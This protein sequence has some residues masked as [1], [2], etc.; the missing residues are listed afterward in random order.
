MKCILRDGDKIN[1]SGFVMLLPDFNKRC[2]Q[3][4]KRS[5]IANVNDFVRHIQSRNY[6]PYVQSI[7]DRKGHPISVSGIP[8]YYLDDELF[9]DI[10]RRDQK[11]VLKWIDNNIVP[12]K[13]PNPTYHTYR[14]KHIIQW[15]TGIYMT[16]NQF[17]DAMLKA[18]Y[19]P[20][21]K[22]DSSWTF[23]I[24]FRNV[25]KIEKLERQGRHIP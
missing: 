10:S 2:Y 24:G 14:L 16:E 17:K 20:I 23:T 13:T 12:R 8:A 6:I 9:R 15:A 5:D 25:R 3:F 22:Y 18:G 1:D 7:I 19:Y 4:R 11:E 21:D